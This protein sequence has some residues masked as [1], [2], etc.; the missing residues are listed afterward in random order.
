M[1]AAARNHDVL[2]L[3][4]L[5]GAAF[6][7]WE[8]IY[9]P[10]KAKK[11]LSLPASAGG[12][13]SPFASTPTIVGPSV[14]P[15]GVQGSIVDP[16]TTPGGD[17]GQAMW[18]K[19]WTETQARMRLTAIK[20]A[21][22]GAI[23]A[24]ARLQAG[25][26]QPEGVAQAQQ[27]VRDNEAA[28]TNAVAQKNAKLAAGD[29]AGAAPW[30]AAETAHRQNIAEAQARIAQAAQPDTAGIAKYEGALASLRADYKAL[31]G[32]DLVV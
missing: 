16:R 8:F 17:V 12:G 27:F 28:L 4:A 24:I 6:L 14:N 25:A 22:R 21:A 2:I 20:D 26:S 31:T 11:D 18:R 7:G 32:L 23:A 3:G 15:G 19:N 30:A 1:A 9:K 13:I 5:G 10:W 29:N